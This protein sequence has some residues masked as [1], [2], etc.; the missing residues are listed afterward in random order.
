MQAVNELTEM[1]VNARSE[2]RDAYRAYNSFHEMSRRYEE[3][4]LPMVTVINDETL[5]KYNGMLVD[6]FE[7][8]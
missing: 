7:L 6:A 3:Q 4:I 1:A 5:L 2:V 8:F